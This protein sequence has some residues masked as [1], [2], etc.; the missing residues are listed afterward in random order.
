MQNYMIALLWTILNAIVIIA[1]F[2]YYISVAKGYNFRRRFLEMAAISLGVALF[3]FLIG[4]V[5]RKWLGVNI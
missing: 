5:I 2:N 1:L 4:N 3:S